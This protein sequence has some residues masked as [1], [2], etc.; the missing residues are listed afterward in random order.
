MITAEKTVS[1]PDTYPL[2]RLGRLEELLFFDIETTGFS[3]EY[4]QLYLIGCTYF[5]DG[6]WRLI[7]WFSDRKD[8]EK[9]LLDSFFTFLRRFTTLVHFNG[10]GFDIPF[11]LKRCRAHGLPYDFSSV[12]SIDIYKKIRPYRTLMGLDSLKQKAIERFLGICRQDPFSGGQLIEVYE[13]YL[14]TRSDRFYDMLML[15]NREDL[16]GMPLILP[17]LY[18]P[19]FFSRDFSLKSQTVIWR[20]ELFGDR[21]PFLSLTLSGSCSLPVDIS[22]EG[23]FCGLAYQAEASGS[24]LNITLEIVSDTLKY[25]Y[26][27][28]ENYYYLIYEDTAIHKSIGGFVEKSARKKATAQTCYTKKEGLFLPQAE[29]LWEP[30]FKRQYRDRFSFV[31]YTPEMLEDSEK[32]N[33]YIRN[34]LTASSR[35]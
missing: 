11:L 26:P 23:N 20:T 18:Y 34:F 12:E 8:S 10:D 5:R 17:I 33:L 14:S 21:T 19:D 7:Q 1:L 6:S 15:H 35:H 28:Y 29:P 13:Q 32:L 25:F 3:G 4:N 27:D 31:L 22:W 30:V 16:E 24:C 9:E 2:S